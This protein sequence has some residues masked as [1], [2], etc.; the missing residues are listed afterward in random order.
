VV[1]YTGALGI[2]NDIET[3]LR[4][5]TLL[6]SRTNIHFLLVG[7]GNKRIELE[8]TAKQTHLENVTFTGPVSKSE[9]PHYLA[10][11]NVCIA[12]LKNISM[13]K[14]T[15]PNKVFDYMAAGRPTI[16][17]IDGVIREVI[18]NANGGVFVEPGNAPA[19]SNAILRLS[20]NPKECRRM[21]RSAR[22]YVMM[23]F[24]RKKQSMAF[25]KLLEEISKTSKVYRACLE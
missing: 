17:A 2:A 21:G 18:E 3:I 10:A 12:S 16:L 13:F 19:L 23:H 15:Y 6:K 8:R 7:G 9:I 4:S 5:A 11:A 24:N 20:Q 22:K 14:T 25:V 1:V